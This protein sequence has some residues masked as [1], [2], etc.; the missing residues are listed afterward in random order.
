MKNIRIDAGLGFYGD[1]WLPLRAT[2]ERGDV[3]YI[4]SDHL[5]E[6]TLAILR[7]DQAKEPAAGYTRDRNP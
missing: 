1:S 6:L 7:K 3:Q 5:S 4:A 2:L